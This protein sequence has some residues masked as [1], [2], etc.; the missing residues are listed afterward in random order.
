[1][2]QQSTNED[3]KEQ[4]AKKSWQARVGADLKSQNIQHILLL[5]FD[6]LKKSVNQKKV[7]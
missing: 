5:S 1:M 6:I 7:L 2:K 3:M 4:Q